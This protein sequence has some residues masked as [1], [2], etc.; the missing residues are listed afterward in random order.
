MASSSPECGVTATD[1]PQLGAKERELSSWP[2]V[3][4]LR[5]TWGGGRGQD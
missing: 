1:D 3:A 4:V 2:E 5:E